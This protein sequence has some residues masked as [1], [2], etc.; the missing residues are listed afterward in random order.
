MCWGYRETVREDPADVFEKR[1]A[2]EQ[3]SKNAGVKSGLTFSLSTATSAGT[4][5]DD[6][7]DIPSVE[8]W[9]SEYNSSFVQS[10]F[11][12]TNSG[13]AVSYSLDPRHSIFL[14]QQADAQLAMHQHQQK[15][16]RQLKLQQQQLAEVSGASRHRWSLRVKAAVGMAGPVQPI[17]FVRPRPPRHDRREPW[18]KRMSQGFRRDSTTQGRVS[19]AA[20]RPKPQGSLPS[21]QL[22]TETALG[23][24]HP[25][26]ST[27]TATFV[28]STLHATLTQAHGSTTTH[29]TTHHRLHE[30]KA[31]ATVVP[32]DSRFGPHAITTP[33]QAAARFRRSVCAVSAF[34]R[35]NTH[36]GASEPAS[37][38]QSAHCALLLGSGVPVTRV[39]EGGGI[40]AP[41][42]ASVPAAAW[43]VQRQSG[44]SA[45]GFGQDA[46]LQALSPV[47][48]FTNSMAN[49][50]IGS[51]VGTPMHSP[52][53]W[54]GNQ[55]ETDTFTSVRLQ[56][57]GPHSSP[58]APFPSGGPTPIMTRMLKPHQLPHALTTTTATAHTNSKTNSKTNPQQHASLS[59]HLV[60]SSTR[61]APQTGHHAHPHSHEAKL[62]VLA[63]SELSLSAVALNPPSRPN[64]A[65]ELISSPGPGY[66][67]TGNARSSVSNNAEN[68]TN[69]AAARVATTA[70]HTGSD[71]T[72]A[73]GKGK[74]NFNSSFGT[75]SSNDTP[76]LAAANKGLRQQLSLLRFQVTELQKTKG[77]MSQ[78]AAATTTTT[79]IPAASSPA[80]FP[81]SSPSQP[82]A[83][84]A[85]TPEGQAGHVWVHARREHGVCGSPVSDV[86]SGDEG[87]EIGNSRGGGF[88]RTQSLPHT[89]LAAGK[90]PPPPPPLAGVGTE[91]GPVSGQWRLSQSFGGGPRPGLE[92]ET[93]LVT[94]EVVLALQ[95]QL[96]G[97]LV[98]WF[99][100]QAREMLK[101]RIQRQLETYNAH[102]IDA[103][104][105]LMSEDVV[106]VDGI[107]GAVIASGVVALRP[108]YE[109]RFAS[110]SVHCELLGRLVL[111]QVVVDREVIS[112][113]P[114][115]GIADCLA[116]YLVQDSKIKRMTFVWQPRSPGT[117]M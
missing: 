52:T 18:W 113:L 98:A 64:S 9:N 4:S 88:S 112:G 16:N 70:N 40:M 58:N 42:N 47:L 79:T 20:E 46:F 49:S 71:P 89:L 32:A 5:S 104:M 24:A 95:S 61:F 11:H 92:D 85:A 84:V 38:T 90:A 74:T 54:G 80:H 28:T 69:P 45:E 60:S 114:D 21:S 116:T 75:N 59:T 37:H 6:L 63:P 93:L 76:T 117:V 53:R 105:A 77:Q 22:G 23:G 91:I 109:A 39:T 17:E 29:A 101:G 94:P 13:T 56:S 106:A 12:V 34:S 107:T 48:H 57:L 35:A 36:T 14:Q 83:A 31:T 72:A 96:E 78:A 51:P 8:L 2:T 27:H 102:D 86:G 62:H 110:R 1:D 97:A 10:T 68:Y 87:R 44:A 30:S 15:Q 55:A 99:K 65:T 82:A 66:Y 33:K 41:P 108:R 67:G 111:G 19:T 50:V 103:F 73:P 7:L 26:S 43:Q 115:G 100:A 81:T 3:A 25:G